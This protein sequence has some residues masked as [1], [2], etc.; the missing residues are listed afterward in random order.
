MADGRDS[1]VSCFVRKAMATSTNTV[2]FSFTDMIIEAP[3]G[4]CGTDIVIP[5]NEGAV[6]DAV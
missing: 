6:A 1:F 5:V 2:A 3:V 4:K